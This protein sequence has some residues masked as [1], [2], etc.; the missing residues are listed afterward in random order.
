MSVIVVAEERTPL[1]QSPSSQ[2]PCRAST[3]EDDDIVPASSSSE[4]DGAN[5]R[6]SVPNQRLVSLD[7][8]RGLTVAVHASIFFMSVANKILRE[9]H[10]DLTV[11]SF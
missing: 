4:Q 3:G 9:L 5:P 11:F 2:A 1:L 10:F 6:S 8:F 7:V